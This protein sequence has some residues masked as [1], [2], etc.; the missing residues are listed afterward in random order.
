MRCFVC[1]TETADGH[2]CPHCGAD[3]LLYKQ[4][5][6]TSD[7][8][9]NEGLSKAQIRDLTGAKNC[10]LQA[11]SYNKY[12]TR[13]RNLLG[14]CYF[15]TGDTVKALNEWIISKNLVPENPMADYYLEKIDKTQGFLNGVDVVVKKYNQAL[16]YCQSGSRDLAIIQLKK[17]INQAPK[18]VEAYQLLALL[19]IFQKK[20]ND[21]RKLLLTAMKIDSGNT[22]TTTY[23]SEVKE[24]LKKDSKKNRYKDDYSQNVDPM[25]GTSTLQNFF[26][27]TRGIVFNMAIG[28]VIGI[29]IAMGLIVPKLNSTSVEKNADAVR[30]TQ[31]AYTK[32]E[33]D[34]KYY[35]NLS[36][37]LQVKLD[38]YEG[39][40]DI[41]GSYEQLMNCLSA[42]NQGD[43]TTAQETLL[44]IDPELLGE[45]GAEKYASLEET[46]MPYVIK[47]EY[48]N[49]LVFY[50]EGNYSAAIT[51]LERVTEY[52]EKYLEGKALFVLADALRLAGQSPRA[53]IYYNKCV[54]LFPNN[55]W[56]RSAENYAVIIGAGEEVGDE[57]TDISDH[58]AIVDADNSVDAQPQN[59]ENV[60]ANAADAA[61]QQ[62]LLQQL[63]QQ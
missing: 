3:I 63:L 54:E 56:G 14:L 62:L 58:D 2:A 55:R 5:I 39:R 23:M 43:M 1:G 6:Y 27:T 18:M 15:E 38:E 61:A 19:Y 46:L 20:Y 40:A 31:E 10:L 44:E 33:A 12:N 51:N 50:Q 29:A 49:A 16:A 42:Y 26:D 25:G 34:Y 22:I 28:V 48:E 53:A 60:D 9:Y 17:V 13:A 37:E 11:L 7:V 30:A 57:P 35:K 32:V 47:Q 45:V 8:L 41:K 36:E 24:L 59:N 4:I 52:D 21:A